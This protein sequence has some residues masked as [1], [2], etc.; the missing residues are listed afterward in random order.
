MQGKY[1]FSHG[2]IQ[3]SSNFHDCLKLAQNEPRKGYIFW[4]LFP[5]VKPMNRIHSLLSSIPQDEFGFI[6]KFQ[7][8]FEKFEFFEL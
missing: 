1:R 2:K 6:L 5:S 7:I 8:S 4:F 3:I